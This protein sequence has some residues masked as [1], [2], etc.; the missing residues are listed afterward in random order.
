[1]DSTTSPARDVA[2]ARSRRRLAWAVAASL[3][4]GALVAALRVEP[5]VW[6]DPGIWLSVGARLLEGDRLY[7]DV[8]DNK[9][10]LFFYSYAVALRIGGVRAPFGLEVLWLGVGTVG[11]ALA[12]RALRVGLLPMLA[13]AL[14]YPFALTA[15]WYVPGATMVPA[16]GL[17]PVALWLFVR[18]SAFAAGAVV[19]ASMLLKLNLGLVVAAPLVALL[20]LGRDASRRRRALEAAGGAVVALLGAVA[21]M[22]S[23]GE[24]LPY[25]D[26]IAYNVYYSDAAINDGGVRAHLDVVREFFAASGKWQ[27]PAAELATVGLLLVVLVGWLRLGTTFKKVSAAAVAGLAASFVTLALT[28]LFTVHVQLLAYPAA[29]GAAT[30]VLAMSGRSRTLAALAAA[31]FVG[32]AAWSSLKN[33]DLSTLTIRTWTKEPLST[34]GTALEATR[35][36]SFPAADRVTYAVL[37]RNTEDGHAAF[38]AH[39]MDLRCR[40]FHQYPFYQREQ[41]D[42][43]LR[44]VDR[45]DPMLIL[46]TT[47]LYDPMPGAPTWEAFVAEARALL[48][49]RYELVTEQGMSQVWRRR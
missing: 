2:Y 18:G 13:G 37:G 38:V 25:L 21:V 28:A 9:D 10:P 34:P 8:F 12:L 3:T 32:F 40:Y 1:M 11:M 36:R 41:L 35:A 20:A 42:E 7:A 5:Q 14:V 46:V 31:A 16:L 43:T 17:A 30:I 4:V 39:A 24:L 45:E 27:L 44:C 26:T 22:A 33:E 49:S 29:L 6:G 19:I 15:A 48:A 47:S 23:R